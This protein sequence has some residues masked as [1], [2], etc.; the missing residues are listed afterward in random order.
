MKIFWMLP[1]IA[2]AAPIAA[3]QPATKGGHELV[4]LGD[5]AEIALVFDTTN[6]GV[7]QITLPKV[8]P[9]KLPEAQRLPIGFFLDLKFSDWVCPSISSTKKDVKK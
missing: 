6:G 3:Q 5:D 9:S 1:A 2:L 4:S 7:A 8:H